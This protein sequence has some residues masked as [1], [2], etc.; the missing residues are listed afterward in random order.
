[1]ILALALSALVGGACARPGEHER[2]ES[3]AVLRV[4]VAQL[5]ATSAIG[6]LRQLTSILS[7]E[8]LA[9]PGEDG[10]MQPLLAE[11]WALSPDGRA[12]T[13]TLKPRVKFHDGSALDPVTVAGVLSTSMRSFMR[14]EEHTS[15]LSHG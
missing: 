9:R 3:T 11:G 7:V 10:R 2:S 1:M 15:E 8:A 5:S 12:L 4:G 6:G 14:S 13:I